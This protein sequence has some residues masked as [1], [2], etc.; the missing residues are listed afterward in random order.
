MVPASFVVAIVRAC[1]TP[2][3]AA[4]VQVPDLDKTFGEVIAADSSHRRTVAVTV[5]VQPWQPQRT[6]PASR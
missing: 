6:E 1:T 3:R 2:P 5:S 4:A